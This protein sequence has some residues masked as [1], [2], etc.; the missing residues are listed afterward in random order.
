V[1]VMLRV[2]FPV[3][4]GN[5]AMRDGTLAKSLQS[6]MEE[7]RPEAAYFLP[8]QGMR[9]AL[10]FLDMKDTTDIPRTV[11]PLFHGLNAAVEITPAMNV[12]DLQAGLRKVKL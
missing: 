7:H 5:R 9:A 2:T 12:D 3:E 6:F 8:Q 4:E 1:R 10:F 11:E